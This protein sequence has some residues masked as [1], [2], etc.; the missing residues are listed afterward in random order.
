MS[1]ASEY[2]A[3]RI[4][5]ADQ[6]NFYTVR[7]IFKEILPRSSGAAPLLAALVSGQR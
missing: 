3:F 2:Q 7:K 6:L 4:Y 1:I 5:Y